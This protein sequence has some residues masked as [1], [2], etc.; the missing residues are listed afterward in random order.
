MIKINI[1]ISYNGILAAVNNG[2]NLND[3]IKIE[4]VT[5]ESNTA[6]QVLI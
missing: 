4:Y 2:T 6:S 1:C 5:K 3:L